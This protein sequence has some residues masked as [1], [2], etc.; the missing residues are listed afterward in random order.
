MEKGFT[1]SVFRGE[2]NISR[3]EIVVISE[4]LIRKTMSN[5]NER[6]F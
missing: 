6:T 5:R 1:A 3:E 4:G 2:I